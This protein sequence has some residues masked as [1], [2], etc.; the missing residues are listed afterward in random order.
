MEIDLNHQPISRVV[1]KVR[2]YT[3]LDIIF[4]NEVLLR[5]LLRL[6]KLEEKI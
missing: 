5:N 3:E 1:N 6:F 2:S 4:E